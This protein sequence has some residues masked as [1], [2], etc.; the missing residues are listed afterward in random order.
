MLRRQGYP[1][2]AQFKDV[3]NT[4]RLWINVTHA[5]YDLIF[6]P[7]IYVNP[8]RQFE[9]CVYFE[10]EKINTSPRTEPTQK[11]RTAILPGAR[12]LGRMCHMHSWPCFGF[13]ST[14]AHRCRLCAGAASTTHICKTIMLILT[15]LISAYATILLHCIH[16]PYITKARTF[17]LCNEPVSF[18]AEGIA[19]SLL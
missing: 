9:D 3:I 1:S 16:L 4:G 14:S 7:R 18:P 17:S 15:N 19:S 10:V 13:G 11:N 8:G 12:D 5:R 2:Q 6:K